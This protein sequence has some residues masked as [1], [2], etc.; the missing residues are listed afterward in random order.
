MK[1]VYSERPAAG[2]RKTVY[3][4][5]LDTLADWE[6]GYLSAELYSKRFFA[7]KETD[8]TVIKE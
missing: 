7:D 3:L 8:C 6:I 5:V 1:D 4:Y 2:D